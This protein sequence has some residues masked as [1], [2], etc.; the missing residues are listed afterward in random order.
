MTEKDPNR[1]SIANNAFGGNTT[2]VYHCI[3]SNTI[4]SGYGKNYRGQEFTFELSA[5]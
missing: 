2:A 3:L 5:R 4:L 1:T